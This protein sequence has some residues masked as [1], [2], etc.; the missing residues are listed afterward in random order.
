MRAEIT[1][2][3]LY[4]ILAGKAAA[5]AAFIAEDENISPLDALTKFYASDT[6]R[7][8]EK[9]ETKYWHFGPIALYQDYCG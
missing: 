5:V 9:E 2:Q 6:Y 3:N 8:L 7:R 4:L 1:Q